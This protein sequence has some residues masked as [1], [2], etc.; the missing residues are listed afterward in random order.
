MA[1]KMR[2]RDFMVSDIILSLVS[3]TFSTRA[4][5]LML[6]TN[7][8]YTKYIAQLFSYV[9]G[10]IPSIF[11]DTSAIADYILINRP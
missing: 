9:K 11:I 2:G 4:G 10:Y 8:C 6:C 7:Y 3:G 1:S 5:Q